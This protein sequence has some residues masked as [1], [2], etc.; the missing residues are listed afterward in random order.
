M[1]LPDRLWRV[2][3]L[4]TRSAYSHDVVERARIFTTAEAAARQVASIR[5][6]A[7]DGRVTL[8][9]VWVCRAE[10]E[11]VSPDALPEPP[12]DVTEHYAALRASR[13]GTV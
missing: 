6:W 3:W 13:E 4:A 2:T 8:V 5:S 10:W 11:A 1:R 7:G 9:G 12:S